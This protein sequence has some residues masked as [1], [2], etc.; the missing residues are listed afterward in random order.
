MVLKD[1]KQ[2]KH[3]KWK[4]SMGSHETIIWENNNLKKQLK[5]YSRSRVGDFTSFYGE[6]FAWGVSESHEPYWS[7]TSILK[8][9]FK[10]KHTALSFA[11]Q[12]MR[13]H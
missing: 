11:K 13:T 10:T 1:W 9:D 7:N 3:T 8:G 4:K 6:I 5:L 2:V 12:Y